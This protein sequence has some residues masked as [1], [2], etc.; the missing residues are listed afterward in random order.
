[1]ACHQG[2][3]DSV[4]FSAIVLVYDMGLL[5]CKIVYVCLY[6]T[7]VAQMGGVMKHTLSSAFCCLLM[8]ILQGVVKLL[9]QLDVMYL[10][11]QFW[12]CLPH[13]VAR[14]RLPQSLTFLWLPLFGI[15]R[16]NCACVPR[17]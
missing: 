7:C 16:I 2:S 9:L 10:S 8:G 5:Q 11:C 13:I 1:M 17:C 15:A 3:V 6:L 12:R 4:W 14:W